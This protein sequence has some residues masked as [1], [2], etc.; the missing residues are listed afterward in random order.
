MIV[1]AGA[2]AVLLGFSAQ[3]FMEDFLEDLIP[4]IEWKYVEDVGSMIVC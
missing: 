1:Q 2:K 4:G 3:K